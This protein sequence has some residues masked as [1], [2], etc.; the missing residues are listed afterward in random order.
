MAAHEESERLALEGELS[1]LEAAWKDA[2][3][4]AAI[5]DDLFLPPEIEERI[6]KGR[7][8]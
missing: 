3:E 4:I 7:A 1:V 5:A 6:R 8:Q 2:E